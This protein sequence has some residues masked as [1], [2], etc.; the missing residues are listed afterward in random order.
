LETHHAGGVE[1][2]LTFL[3]AR[4]EPPNNRG[5]GRVMRSGDGCVAVLSKNETFSCQPG[6][7]SRQQ[8]LDMTEGD[9]PLDGHLRAAD[10]TPKIRK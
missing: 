8:L 4:Y 2:D 3:A 9:R 1:A 5:K 10:S 7:V 6:D